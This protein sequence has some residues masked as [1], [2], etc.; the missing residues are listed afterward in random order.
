MIGRRRQFRGGYRFA[1]FEGQPAARLFTPE[2]PERVLIPLRQGFRDAVR[3]VVRTGDKVR[4][5]QTVGIDDTGVSSPVH[6]SVAGVVEEVRGPDGEEN[7]AGHIVIRA[8]PSDSVERL[9]G[10]SPNWSDLP[11]EKIEDL[12]YASGVAA[13]G[14]GGIPTRH[15]SSIIAPED[16]EAV[17]VRDTGSEMYHPSLSVILGESRLGAFAEGLRILQKVLN[18]APVHVAVNSREAELIERLSNALQDCD[19]VRVHPRNPVYPGD[20]AEVL[21]PALLGRPFPHGYAPANIGVVVLDCQAVVHA[22]EAVVEGKPLTER[23]VALCGPG[24]RRTSHARVAIGT[25]LGDL[26]RQ[27]GANAEDLRFIKNSTLTGPK[28]PDA[29]CPIDRTFSTIVALPERTETGLL[30]FIRPG[31]AEDGYARTFLSC[32][33]PTAR[34][35][36][37]SLKGEPRPCVSCGYCQDVCPTG[38][39][40]HLLY[41]YAARGYLEENLVDELRIFDCIGCNLC[42]YVCPSKIGL[43]RH[44]KSGREKLLQEGIDNS[45]NILPFFSLKGLENEGEAQ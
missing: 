8:R 33:L 30:P 16:V 20:F 36:S 11:A 4:A 34:K 31:P 43:G 29:M 1:R 35:A 26:A 38:I 22:Y 2:G 14:D 10:C 42:S 39:I 32:L 13:L 25:P 24:F 12:L 28:L 40:P 3:P 7:V 45:A 37:A 23:I 19:S 27:A 5:G 21:I 44:I 15:S 17:I 18:G 6:A 41:K 9:S